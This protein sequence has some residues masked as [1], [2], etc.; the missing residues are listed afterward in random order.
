VQVD[1]VFVPKYVYPAPTWG[2]WG[3]ETTESETI[4]VVTGTAAGVGETTATLQGTLTALGGYSPVY[5]SF[6]YG[7]TT[8]YG[9]STVEQ[10]R[11]AIG[12]FNQAIS[13][14]TPDTTYHFKAVVRYDITSYAY[15]SDQVFV[16]LAAPVELQPPTSFTASR[17]DTTIDLS[18]VKAS[19]AV[20]TLV[21]RST[22]TFPTSVT[23]DTEVYFGTGSG[24]TD[25][26]LNNAQGYYYSAWSEAGGIYSASY[27]TVYS[28]PEGTGTGILPPPDSLYIWTVEIYESYFD[29]GDQLI[30][31]MYNI[32]YSS[33]EPTQDVRDFFAIEVWDG[34]ALIARTPVMAWGEKPGSVYLAPAN[35][36]TW[37]QA[38]TIKIRGLS[39]QWTVIPETVYNV[40]NFHWTWSRDDF[41]GVLKTWCLITA[42]A[43]DPSWV[44]ATAAGEKLSD[45]AY[46]I[47]N[48]AI[49]SL[50][51]KVPD[52]FSSGTG[53][54][55]PAKRTHDPEYQGELPPENAGNMT[56]ELLEE[57]AGTIG[58][59]MIDFGSM[60]IILLSVAA[61]VIVGFFTR[62]VGFS[63]AATLPIISI[64]LWIGVVTLAWIMVAAGVLVLY[65]VYK[66]VVKGV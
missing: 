35:T 43:V 12:S 17:G 20:N 6:R 19:G 21:R 34:S 14:L 5:V 53:F 3:T 30:C 52:L 54:V 29:T 10:E 40:Q 64:G 15:G 45:V 7:L 48:R 23:S 36:L 63:I 4:A 55:D 24:Y 49:P 1:W 26:S 66:L 50:S 9:S 28:P 31:L 58:M 42:N 62:S 13:G 65:W 57:G 32:D 47:Y 22:I 41:T 8:T 37:G 16:T 44:N 51:S 2:G 59:E 61:M 56:V 11:T 18:W 60:I 46:P 25:N 33:G 38:F 27:A 39:S